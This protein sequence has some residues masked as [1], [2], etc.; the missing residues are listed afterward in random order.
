[1]QQE[2]ER[3]LWGAGH[4]FGGTVDAG[5]YMQYV[6]GLLSHLGHQPTND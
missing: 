5:G 2:L 6:F 3:R 1:M 4:I